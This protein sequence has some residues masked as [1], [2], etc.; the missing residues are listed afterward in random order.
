MVIHSCEVED[1]VVLVGQFVESY[2]YYF[3]FLVSVQ[4][5]LYHAFK[6]FFAGIVK[7]SPPICILN[8]RVSPTL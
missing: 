4:N 2:L 7:D 3:T 5:L 6:S 8:I 1:V